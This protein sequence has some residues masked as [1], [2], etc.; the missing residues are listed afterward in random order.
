MH[1]HLQ[2][3]WLDKLITQHYIQGVAKWSGWFY[4]HWVVGFAECLKTSFQ[5]RQVRWSYFPTSPPRTSSIKYLQGNSMRKPGVPQGGLWW[6][7]SVQPFFDRGWEGSK[8]LNACNKW[9]QNKKLVSLRLHDV[10]SVSLSCDV[11]RNCVMYQWRS[12]VVWRFF[13]K[14]ISQEDCGPFK[15]HFRRQFCVLELELIL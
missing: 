8:R 14:P 2:L 6:I 7:G 15:A 12:T 3:V 5:R 13:F 11:L 9:P 10:L 1:V 4:N